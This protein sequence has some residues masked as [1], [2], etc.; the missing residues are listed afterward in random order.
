MER[1]HRIKFNHIKRL[2]YFLK[3]QSF[4]LLIKRVIQVLTKNRNIFRCLQIFDFW[5]VYFQ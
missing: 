3:K 1:Y 2:R 4:I 5:C